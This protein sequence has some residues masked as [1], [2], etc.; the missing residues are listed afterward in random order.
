MHLSVGEVYLDA[1]LVNYWQERLKVRD[2][3]SAVRLNFFQS[4]SIDPLAC[5]K[6]P[7]TI[8]TYYLQLMALG[9]IEQ[10]LDHSALCG[11]LAFESS[12]RRH[13]FLEAVLGGNGRDERRP[14]RRLLVASTALVWRTCWELRAVLMV[15]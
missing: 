1:V 5:D 7:N 3:F 8:Y 15:L 9:L 10:C 14:R 4:T 2:S 12:R 11:I 6:N 13:V